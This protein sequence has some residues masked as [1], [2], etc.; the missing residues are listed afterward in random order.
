MGALRIVSILAQS[1]LYTNKHKTVH[2]CKQNNTV[3][4]R[5]TIVVADPAAPPLMEVEDI[6]EGVIP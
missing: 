2:L 3:N 5:I 1:T 6:F 4:E